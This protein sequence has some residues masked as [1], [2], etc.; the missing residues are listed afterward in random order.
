MAQKSKG[1]IQC[2]KCQKTFSRRSNLKRHFPV[3]T[4]Q[5]RFWCDSCQRGFTSK[6]LHE[7]HMR[8]H[9]GRLYKCEYCSKSYQTRIGLSTHLPEHTGKY[10]FNCQTCDA[11]FSVREKLKLHENKHRG[12]STR[13]QCPKCP[14]TFSRQ[15][16]LKRHFSVHTGLFKFLCNLCKKGFHEKAIYTDHMRKHDGTLLTCR[17]CSKSFQS[18]IAFQQHLKTHRGNLAFYEETRQ[19]TCNNIRDLNSHENKHSGYSCLWCDKKFY[20]EKIF[21]KHEQEC[22]WECL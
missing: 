16:G 14:K 15:R 13:I 2:S 6:S 9:E 17:Y 10:P 20:D 1:R 3:H 4:G 7:D 21:K 12:L 8:K 19:K 18:S 22:Q 5:F 11:G